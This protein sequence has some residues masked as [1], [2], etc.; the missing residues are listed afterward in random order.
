MQLFEAD[1]EDTKQKIEACIRDFGWAAEH[2]AIWYG[3]CG[4]RYQPT[5]NQK[6]AEKDVVAFFD[7]GYGLLTKEYHGSTLHTEVFSEPLAPPGQRASILHQYTAYA[8]EKLGVEKVVLELCEETRNDFLR[9]LPS[10]LKARAP[11]YTMTWPVVNLHTFDLGLPGKH[12]RN[13]RNARN[14]FYREHSVSV[15]EAKHADAGEMYDIVERWRVS[16]RAKDRTNRQKYHN[17]IEGN[18]EGCDDVFLLRIDGRPA[19]VSAGWMIPHSPC[20]YL[21][22]ILNDYS[23]TDLG[24][25]LYFETFARLKKKGIQYVDLGGGEKTLTHFKNQFRPERSYETHV[26]S[27]V[28][29]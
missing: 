5:G 14:K 2:H 16:R 22:V 9:F 13:L 25:I 3:C 27:V 15:E 17:V 12:F 8:L 10:G 23:L 28:A 11:A 24:L 18:F 19:G 4:N 1:N 21:A 20:Y 7:G 26:F 6:K 29:A